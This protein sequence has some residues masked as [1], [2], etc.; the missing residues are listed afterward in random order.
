MK[1]QDIDPR[2]VLD[3]IPAFICSGRPDGSIDYFNRRWLDEV[4]A[5]QDALEGWGW[6]KFIH[7]DDLEEHLRRWQTSMASGD[8]IESQARVRRSNGEYRW[9]LHRVQPV[10]DHLGHIVRWFGSSID[11]EESRRADETIRN[12]ERELRTILETIPAFVWTAGPD[13]ALEF[14]T[15]R[16]FQRMRHT[17]EEVVG[18]KWTSMIHPDDRD[19]VLQKWREAITAGRS[20]RS[21]NA[22]P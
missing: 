10:R 3:S 16:W 1:P 9:M 17:R 13:G 20:A 2:L 7:P 22:W 18:W 19:R 14:L 11:I 15:E 4:G 8:T 5:A 6:T 21:G 12:T